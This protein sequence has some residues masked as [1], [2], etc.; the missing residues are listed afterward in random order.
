MERAALWAALVLFMKMKG[1]LPPKAAGFQPVA[2]PRMFL[3]QRRG[4]IDLVNLMF[5][6]ERTGVSQVNTA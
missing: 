1:A 3:K 2:S 4:R 6:Y 5:A